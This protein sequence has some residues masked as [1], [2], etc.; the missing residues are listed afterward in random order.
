MFRCAGQ[1]SRQ[2]GKS[3]EGGVWSTPGSLI[4]PV[5]RRAARTRGGRMRF[6]SG[7]C[8]VMGFLSAWRKVSAMPLTNPIIATSQNRQHAG[9]QHIRQSKREEDLPAQVHQLIDTHPGKS[10]PEPNDHEHDGVSLDK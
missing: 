10:P 5:S 3:G 8:R 1:A 2:S 4:I 6:S 7:Y 9:Y